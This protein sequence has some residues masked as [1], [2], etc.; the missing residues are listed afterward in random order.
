MMKKI[1]LSILLCLPF[2][3]NAKEAESVIAD[4]VLHERV[5]SVSAELRCL[6]CQGQSLADSHSEFAVDMRQQIQDMMADGMSNGE[7]IDF[8]V[9][10]YGD[11]VR[12]RP[13]FNTVT[14]ILWFGP[15]TL[16]AAGIGVLYFNIARRKKQVVDAPLS[17]D[18]RHQAEA[19]LKD[20]AGD[21]K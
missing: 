12:Y 14:V 21:N 1:L 18:D 20:D 7:V 4:P 2:V 19:L 9:Q 11:T 10:R 17:D 5:M 16:L 13:P 3:V 8:M 15:F 6:V